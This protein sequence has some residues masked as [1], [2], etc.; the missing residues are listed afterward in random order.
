MN[1][2]NVPSTGGKCERR[3][4]EATVCIPVMQLMK[5]GDMDIQRFGS[6]QKASG[7]VNPGRSLKAYK[8]D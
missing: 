4:V 3:Q 6:L 7:D 8:Q 2:L 1:P 5:F